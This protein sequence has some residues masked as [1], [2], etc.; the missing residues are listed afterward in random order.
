MRA[1]HKYS[2]SFAA[3]ALCLLISG[4]S[5]AAREA[6]LPEQFESIKEFLLNTVSE[7]QRVG[8]ATTYALLHE[9]LSAFRQLKVQV[10]EAAHI[11]HVIDDLSAELDNIASNF[12][13]AARLR[14]DYALHTAE[15]DRD[16]HNK[17][18]Q[19]RAAIAEIER[20]ISITQDELAA[21]RIAAANATASASSIDYERSQITISAS[22]SVLNSL[23]AQ[24][25]IWQ[26][27]EQAQ[28]RLVSTLKISTE[29][30][31]FVLFVL[32][33]NARVYREASNTAQLRRNVR[34]ALNDLQ[35]LGAIES[36]LTDLAASWREVDQIVSEIGREEFGYAGS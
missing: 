13:Q 15:S 4:N 20:R 6:P 19:T 1:R 9:N 23:Q 25:E 26:R 8:A 14:S 27:F 7:S 29:R 33:N 31:D 32:E 18:R 36:S 24:I 2:K 3:L 17:R 11:D 16:L 5:S 30:V 22:N 12:E 10:D 21:A 28:E 34:M 35:S